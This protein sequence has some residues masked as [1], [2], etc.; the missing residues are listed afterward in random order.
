MKIPS[1]KVARNG[2]ILIK[3]PLVPI[4]AIKLPKK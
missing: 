3:K 1:V 4:I 2:N